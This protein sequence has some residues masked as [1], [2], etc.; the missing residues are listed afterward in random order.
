VFVSDLGGGG[1]D[2]S[3]YVATD[4]WFHGHLHLSEYSRHVFGHEGNA[5]ARVVGGGVDTMR[6]SPDPAVPRDG[7]ALFVGRL[8]PHKGVGDLVLGLPPSVPLTIVGPRPDAA[9]EAQ[10]REWSRGRQ[11]T[12]LFDLGDAALVEQYQRALCV[13]LPSVYRTPAGETKVP[14]LLGQTLLEGMACGAAAVCTRV[15]SLPEV[16][17]DGVT[18]FVVPPNDPAAIG[19]RLQWLATHRDEAGRMGAAGRARVLD[20]F[21]WPAVIARCLDAYRAGRLEAAA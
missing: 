21:T 7:G 1:W 8:L 3:A 2:I 9:A 15:A 20:R 17:E 4:A 18:G 10:L 16:V 5:R 11:V 19:E 6:F 12:R 13:V 14:E